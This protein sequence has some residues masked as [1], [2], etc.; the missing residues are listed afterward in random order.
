LSESGDH[1]LEARSMSSDKEALTLGKGHSAVISSVKMSLPSA[2]C[3]G[4]KTLGKELHS[5]K[6]K[7]KKIQK[8]ETGKKNIEGGMHSQLVTHLMGC[9]FFSTIF[10]KLSM[11]VFELTTSCT[12][13]T[14]STTAPLDQVCQHYVFILHVL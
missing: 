5:A 1:A 2:F 6:C 14:L 4:Q 11:I 9:T 7:S 12:Q 13:T 10:Y 3:R 8:N